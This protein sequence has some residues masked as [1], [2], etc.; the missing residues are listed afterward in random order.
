MAVYFNYISNTFAEQ[1]KSFIFKILLLLSQ[2]HHL[3]SPTLSFLQFNRNLR[4]FEVVNFTV[5][6]TI[7]EAPDSDKCLWPDSSR[8][9]LTEADT[10]KSPPWE[11]VTLTQKYFKVQK[12]F[13]SAVWLVL[14]KINLYLIVSL[15]FSS[16]FRYKEFQFS[17]FFAQEQ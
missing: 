11:G 16:L 7:S 3:W 14:Q 2:L 12:L 13:R 5:S 4:T 6:G 9:S 10:T 15:G 17:H 8:V 1:G